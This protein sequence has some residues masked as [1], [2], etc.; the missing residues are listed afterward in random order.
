VSAW[1]VVDYLHGVRVW[2]IAWEWEDGGEDFGVGSEVEWYLFP[3]SHE[4][5]V[6]NLE[7]LGEELLGSITHSTSPDEL[8]PAKKRSEAVRTRGRVESLSA[9]YFRWVRIPW[10]RRRSDQ[11]GLGS[12]VLKIGTWL[13]PRT[14]RPVV[15]SAVLEARERPDFRPASDPDLGGL[16]GYIVDLSSVD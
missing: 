8:I 4:E 1:R 9:V 16:E 2:L 15:G 6:Y 3:L 12:S 13:G 14:Y 7:P 11:P 10:W 5:R